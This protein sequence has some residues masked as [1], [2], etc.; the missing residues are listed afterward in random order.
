MPL[1]LAGQSHEVVALSG[2]GSGGRMNRP[3]AEVVIPAK[4]GI[5]RFSNRSIK[6]TIQPFLTPFSGFG[7]I[8]RRRGRRSFGSI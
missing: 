1:F 3:L 7:S 2:G 4:A 5:Q 8:G 6:V